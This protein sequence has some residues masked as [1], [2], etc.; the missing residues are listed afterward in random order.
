MG[1]FVGQRP[2]DVRVHFPDDFLNTR[3]DE[4]TEYISRLEGDL[5]MQ[6]HLDKVYHRQINAVVGHNHKN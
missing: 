3:H 2:E 6:D 1:F 4:V 5:T